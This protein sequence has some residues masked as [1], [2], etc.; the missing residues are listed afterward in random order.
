MKRRLPT[1]PYPMGGYL[2]PLKRLTSPDGIQPRISAMPPTARKSS[3][4]QQRALLEKYNISIEGP[5]RPRDWPEKYSSIFA[6][7]RDAEKVCYEVY[8]RTDV[9]NDI[10]RLLQVAQMS[11]RVEELV[12]RAYNLRMTSA[13]EET[14]RMETE[15]LILQRFKAEVDCHMCNKR[16]WLSDIQA[17][18]SCPIATEKLKRIQ[19]TR[20]LCRCEEPVR[21]KWLAGS[22]P[23]QSFMAHAGCTVVDNSMLEIQNKVLAHHKPDRVISLER[24]HDIKRLMAAND[25]ITPTVIKNDM[26]S[27]FPFLVIEAKSEKGTVGFDSIERQTAFPIRAMLDIQKRLETAGSA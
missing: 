27:C 5:V 24:T 8:Y 18:P 22:T 25:D 10:A 11:N 15:E 23:Q 17:L 7:V 21:A 2:P 26:D 13:N 16:R 12:S 3:P 6:L 1:C 19:S 4:E 20:S 14:W 9:R